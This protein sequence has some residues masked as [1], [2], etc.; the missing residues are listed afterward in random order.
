MQA[1]FDDSG[2]SD[3]S[4]TVVA[5]YFFR[6]AVLEPFR[7]QWRGLL[8][9]RRFHMVDL[10]HGNE[11][12]ADLKELER[13]TLARALISTIKEYVTLGVVMSLERAAYDRYIQDVKPSGSLGSPYSLCSM[14]CLGASAKWMENNEVA[15]EETVYFFESGN[16]KQTEA[17][18]FL[19]T[20]TSNPALDQRYRYVSHSFVKKN[21]LASL[22]A[23]DLL[24]W[25]WTQQCRRFSGQ[26]QRPPRASLRSLCEKPHIGQHF[27]GGEV[28]LAFVRALLEPF[29]VPSMGV[30]FERP[31]ED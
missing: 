29:I 17:N 23:A 19:N 15:P 8:G 9:G 12:F 11:D 1:S 2:N 28:R 22:D 7:D 30:I 20:I 3:K 14:L 25:E 13:D 31:E 6:D 24:G 21:K 16:S 27:Q 5:G 26:E 4:L 10:V 18:K